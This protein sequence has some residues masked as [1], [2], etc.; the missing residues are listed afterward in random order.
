MP[1]VHIHDLPLEAIAALEQ[2]AAKNERSL[3]VEIR[4]LLLEIASQEP[5]TEPLQPLR[6][7]FSPAPQGT[8]W[9]R[10]EIYGDD[11]R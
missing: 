8:T 3:E 7:N 10:K 9:P 4:L 1:A 6:L 2:R 11:G 5:S